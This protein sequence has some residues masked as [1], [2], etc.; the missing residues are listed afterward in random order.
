MLLD[1]MHD[2]ASAMAGQPVL[3]AS[4]IDLR[5]LVEHVAGEVG[6]E[7]R[8]LGREVDVRYAFGAPRFLLGDD[9]CLRQLLRR[10]LVNCAHYILGPFGPDTDLRRAGLR[11]AERG[12]K[13]AKK[14]A[15][16]AVARRLAV[17]LHRLWVTG[18]VY[19][20]LRREAS[21]AA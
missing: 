20:P 8:A 10:L 7:A 21:K 3:E 6:D 11:M 16:V 17:L 15:I 1:K 18:E 19:E 4:P 13:A 14:R 2:V 5:S 9:D 12:G